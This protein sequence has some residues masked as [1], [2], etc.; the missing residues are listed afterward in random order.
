MVPRNLPR[1]ADG[2]KCAGVRLAC[3]L[4]GKLAD[5]VHGFCMDKERTLGDFSTVV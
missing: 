4:G 1:Q 3:R 5:F 2:G